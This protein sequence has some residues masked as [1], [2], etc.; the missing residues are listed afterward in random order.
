M[1][2]KIYILL[3][4]IFCFSGLVLILLSKNDFIFSNLDVV[5]NSQDTLKK[6]TILIEE[7]IV[8][9]FVSLDSILNNNYEDSTLVLNNTIEENILNTE[10]KYLVIVGSFKVKENAT[11]LVEELKIMGFN[12]SCIYEANNF[13]YAVID[14]YS[15]R[16]AA[17]ES[18]INSKL[19]GWVKKK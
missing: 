17:K 7:A 14:S 2:N 4:L 6:D 8:E 10:F 15:S 19:D 9:T 3:G 1:N 5:K 13:T 18:L 12:S 16:E 11:K